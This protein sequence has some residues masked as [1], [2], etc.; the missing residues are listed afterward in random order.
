MH[1][2]VS[3]ILSLPDELLEHI[4]GLV[5]SYPTRS[6]WA[7][8]FDN[9]FKDAASVVLVCRRFWC[10]A[11]PYLY[12]HIDVAV[13]GASPSFPAASS[14]A[15]EHLHKT[16]GRDG[17]LREHCRILHV[18]LEDCPGEVPQR[19]LQ[20]FASWL[21][22]TRTLLVDYFWHAGQTANR[23]DRAWDF[24]RTAVRDMACLEDITL[25]TGTNLL[26]LPTIVETL[27]DAARLRTVTLNGV[28]FTGFTLPSGRFKV[29]SLLYI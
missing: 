23:R 2:P 20:D 1:R 14:K 26:A 8:D 4:L 15:T 5:V 13:G 11:T 17:S 27:C 28:S 9:F 22:R 3:K 24:I 7:P 18:Y 19:N 21:A 10:L 6:W 29:H 12:R 16:L 25:T